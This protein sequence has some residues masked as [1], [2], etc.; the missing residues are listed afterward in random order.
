MRAI[1]MD[2][3]SNNTKIVTNPIFCTNKIRKKKC[4]LIN[5]ATFVLQEQEREEVLLL[6]EIFVLDAINLKEKKTVSRC[7]KKME[8]INKS[9]MKF[10][11]LN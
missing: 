4:C 3:K 9:E 1:I 10:R 2:N 6:S 5:K 11:D 8:I 7:Q